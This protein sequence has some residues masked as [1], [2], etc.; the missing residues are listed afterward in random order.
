MAELLRLVVVKGRG[1]LFV[2]C[3]SHSKYLSIPVQNWT[4]FIN[5]RSKMKLREQE[6]QDWL[7]VGCLTWTRMIF[8]VQKIAACNGHYPFKRIFVRKSLYISSSLKRQ[9]INAFS[10]LN[11]TVSL[12]QS[13]WFGGKQSK[14]SHQF[15]PLFHSINQFLSQCFVGWQ[16]GHSR[17]LK[18]L[19]QTVSMQWQLQIF[20]NTFDTAGDTWMPTG[21]RFITCCSRSLTWIPSEWA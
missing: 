20:G 6:Y 7:T 9:G 16:I 3:H 14:V 4:Q 18:S 13:R 8:L 2:T 17:R 10:Y 5:G 19:F 15:L 12:I 21:K 11:S 1:L